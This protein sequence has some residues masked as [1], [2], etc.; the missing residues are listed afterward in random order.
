MNNFED[1]FSAA[2]VHIWLANKERNI[3][4]VLGDPRPGHGRLD[5]VFI[6]FEKSQ[7]L[8]RYPTVSTPMLEPRQLW[9]SGV[10]G[11]ELRL[12]KP[13]LPPAGMIEQIHSLPSERCAAIIH[14]VEVALGVPIEWKDG[15]I[16]V[17]SQRAARIQHLAEVLWAMN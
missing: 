3:G 16:D 4:N 8:R 2:V 15:S 12:Q 11:N 10:L 13:L 14:D 9:P 5:L 17:L 1:L 7:A 6:D